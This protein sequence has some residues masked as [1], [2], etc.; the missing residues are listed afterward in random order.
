MPVGRKPDMGPVSRGHEQ[1]KHV[2][3]QD[4]SWRG[5][6]IEIKGSEPKTSF[7]Q[8]IF[9]TKGQ[10]AKI[11]AERKQLAE[12]RG[13]VQE[14]KIDM[15]TKGKLEGREGGNLHTQEGILQAVAQLKTAYASL[16]KLDKSNQA[17]GA[18]LEQEL[19]KIENGVASPLYKQVKEGKKLLVKAK[20]PTDID[21][22]KQEIQKLK[23]EVKS[24]VDAKVHIGDLDQQIKALDKAIILKE[25]EI[26]PEKFQLEQKSTEQVNKLRDS[27]RFAVRTVMEGRKIK[28]P[29]LESFIKSGFKEETD[30]KAL[31]KEALVILQKLQTILV[32]EKI[33]YESNDGELELGNFVEQ[34]VYDAYVKA[35]A[36]FNKF[37]VEPKVKPEDVRHKAVEPSVQDVHMLPPEDASAKETSLGR[38]RRRVD[39][40]DQLRAGTGKLSEAFGGALGAVHRGLTGMAAHT[41]EGRGAL[42]DRP[43]AKQAPAAT[44]GAGLGDVAKK[45]ARGLG[46]VATGLAGHSVS[47]DEA[48][49]A[50]AM[51]QSRP[52]EAPAQ[53]AAAGKVA[54]PLQG[55]PSKEGDFKEALKALQEG[56]EAANLQAEVGKRDVVKK[57]ASKKNMG[58]RASIRADLLRIRK[59]VGSLAPIKAKM[60]AAEQA[61]EAYWGEKL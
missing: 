48:Q 5:K 25:K 26:S 36:A 17:E 60:T 61:F 44:K 19:G 52:S 24:Y 34:D 13:K 1:H 42:Q 29:T 18:F 51:F 59:T 58:D 56:I 53:A 7:L 12:I 31:E 49:E 16:G 9:Q 28:E 4:T 30:R 23:K 37:E 55:D 10:K 3:K 38:P 32:K 15:L 8:G 43:P 47:P 45:V 39:I 27:L 46:Q 20:K 21:H 35:F 41:V 11:N 2:E 14:L 40:D 50:A 6:S 33:A 22:L 54:S 57:L